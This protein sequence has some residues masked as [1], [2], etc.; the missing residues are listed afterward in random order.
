MNRCEN[1]HAGP[2]SEKNP[3]RD[4]LERTL[5]SRDAAS[6]CSRARLSIF[7]TLLRGQADEMK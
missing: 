5:R 2:G 1:P 7:Q 6:A 3:S 4:L